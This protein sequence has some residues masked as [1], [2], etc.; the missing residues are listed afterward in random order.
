MK[1][2]VNGDALVLLEDFINSA[3][4]LYYKNVADALYYIEDAFVQR[5]ILLNKAIQKAKRESDKR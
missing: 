2:D 3:T 4:G 5:A 1:I